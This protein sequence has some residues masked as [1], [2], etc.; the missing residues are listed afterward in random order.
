MPFE[1]FTFL[2]GLEFATFSQL[3][4]FPPLWFK[5]F[6]V[7]QHRKHHPDQ[8]VRSGQD[9]LLIDEPFFPSFEIVRAEN[10]IGDNHLGRHEP[11]NPAE[12]T[13]SSL[14]DFALPF[15]LA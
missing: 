12:M 11:D 1:I 5:T 3:Y 6:L 9:G 10:R 15:V 14:A 13:I 7:Y 8:L 4:L 2:K